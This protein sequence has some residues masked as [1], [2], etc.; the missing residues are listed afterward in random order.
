M[1]F[2][3]AKIKICHKN[4]TVIL[5]DELLV[6]CELIVLIYSIIINI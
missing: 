3:I 2:F 1:L 4:T 5:T 6:T